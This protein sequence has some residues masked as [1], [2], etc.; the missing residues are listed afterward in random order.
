M[1]EPSEPLPADLITALEALQRAHPGTWHDLVAD[2]VVAVGGTDAADLL[3][4]TADRAAAGIPRDG[5]GDP[6]AALAA[7]EADLR[8]IEADLGTTSA[9]T[10]DLLAELPKL[11]PKPDDDKPS[12]SMN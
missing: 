10:V 7:M 1:P 12:R 8:A 3:A 5:E 11:P 2:A 4:L 6:E 9:K